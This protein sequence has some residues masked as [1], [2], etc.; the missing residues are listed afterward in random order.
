MSEMN[1]TETTTPINVDIQG[2]MQKPWFE[3]YRPEV[4]E[5]I[6]F[7]N[8]I[9][10]NKIK[11]FIS[12][13][14][15]EG[16]ILSYGPGGTGK[17]TVNKVLAWAILKN[18]ADFHILGKGV[19]DIESLKSW[20][21]QKAHSSVQK[22]VIA[23]E[24]DRVTKEAQ[25]MLKDGL[26][27]KYMPKVAFLCTTNNINSI[28]PALLQR[29]NI[30]LNFNTFNIEGVYNRCLK[31]LEME[32]V[33][34][35]PNQVYQ[36]VNMFKN[37]GIRDLLNSLEFGVI[38]NKF[39]LANITAN[40]TTTNM[41]DTLVSW[42]KY[43]FLYIESQD[44][45]NMYNIICFPNNDPNIGQY[46]NEL[47]RQLEIDT[48]INYDYIFKTLL[49]DPEI[50]LNMK[51]PLSLYYDYF[52]RAKLKNVK[53]MVCLFEVM[54]EIYAMAGGTLQLKHSSYMFR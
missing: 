10:E 24:F 43:I 20:I 52:E 25:I 40:V 42:I 38:D 53:F 49:D 17:T 32:K 50:K 47:I 27:E 51:A 13:G 34:Y 35:D 7:E 21:T 8:S 54:T 45:N 37:K 14:F 41:E 11:K 12:N 2:L 23:E 48:S 26:M 15:I 29:F 1:G 44:V 31:I 22:I 9:V 5:D 19:K 28:D 30:K 36:L 16:N 3:K 39:D 33:Q 46:Y 18:E 4:V 6:V